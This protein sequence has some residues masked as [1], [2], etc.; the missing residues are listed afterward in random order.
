MEW[1]KAFADA[2]KR[3]RKRNTISSSVSKSGASLTPSTAS[4][5]DH[6]AMDEVMNG[7]TSTSN[8]GTG[9]QVLKKQS[10]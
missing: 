7:V 9:V 6:E 8:G 1:K 3:N 5:I 4:A 2:S 10:G